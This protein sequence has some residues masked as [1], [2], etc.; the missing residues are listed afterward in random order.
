MSPART[1]LLL[2]V[3]FGVTLPLSVVV[4]TNLARKSFEKVKLR[5]QTINVK[6]YAERRIT[7]DHATWN[8]TIEAQDAD[9]KQAYVRV[10]SGRAKLV[11]A[12]TS[13]GVKPD[14]LK[15]SAT[16]YQT[17]FRRDEKGNATNQIEGY[18]VSQAFTFETGN[19]SLAE[20]A[21]QAAGEL[22]R[23]GVEIAS[24]AP[25][26]RYTKMDEM[27]LQMLGEASANARA[28]AEMLIGQGAGHLGSLKS[29]SQGVFQIT[30]PNSTEVS[31]AGENDTQSVD[32]VIKAVVTLEF[33]IE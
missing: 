5:D 2:L 23:D 27:K 11:D 30:S 29:A 32:K 3:L 18:R 14:M 25:Q 9:L 13:V 12:M 33:G 28:R 6:G 24:A 22:I 31:D 17:L 20:K 15:A 10:E 19:V 1:N 16:N 4:S 7:S 26:F 21:S 8:G